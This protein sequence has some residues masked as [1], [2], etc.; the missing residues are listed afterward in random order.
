MKPG[1]GGVGTPGRGPGPNHAVASA[2]R[3]PGRRRARAVGGVTGLGRSRGRCTGRGAR[4]GAGPARTAFERAVGQ[5]KKPGDIVVAPA[6][7]PSLAGFTPGTITAPAALC[8][9]LAECQ[10]IGAASVRE[11]MSLDACSV[12]ALMIHGPQPS[13]EPMGAWSTRPQCAYTQPSAT[14]TSH[15]NKAAH[16]ATHVRSRSVETH[17]KSTRVRCARSGSR[18]RYHAYRTPQAHKITKVS[19]G[20]GAPRTEA[21][22]RVALPSIL[23]EPHDGTLYMPEIVCTLS[24]AGVTRTT[25]SGRRGEPP[26]SRN[27]GC[28]PPWGPHLHVTPADPAGRFFGFRLCAPERHRSET[29][30]KLPRAAPK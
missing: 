7:A 9:V 18:L 16:L 14:E 30:I 1:D 25:H 23:P 29:T 21:A 17:Q 8:G 2:G 11:D 3:S 22:Q 5:R 10:R 15:P 28:P 6:G 26:P 19:Q 27:Q 13:S 4:G 20:R 24:D 12:A